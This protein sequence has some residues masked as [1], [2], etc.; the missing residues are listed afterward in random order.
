[1]SKNKEITLTLI[2]KN[3][4]KTL[5]N[6]LSSFAILYDLIQIIDT[7]SIDRTK[8]IALK[9]GAEIYDF[10]WI[11][12]FSAARNFGLKKVKTEWIMTVDAD[13]VIEEEDKNN[14]INHFLA[15]N[16]SDIFVLPYI[17][18]GTKT[19]PQT[20]NRQPRIWKSNLNLKYIRPIHER[21]SLPEN[22]KI[23]NLDIPIIHTKTNPIQASVQRN[24][25]ILN[26]HI[27]NNPEDHETAYYLG[28]EYSNLGDNIKSIEFY[29]KYLQL[30]PCN[31]TNTHHAHTKL[32]IIKMQQGKIIDAKKHFQTSIKLQPKVID[33][34]LFLAEI[35][36]HLFSPTNAIKLLSIAKELKSPPANINFCNPHLYSG[37]ADQLL[38]IA[39]SKL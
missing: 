6:C 20:I 10:E 30:E 8:E 17:Y 12:D 21:L 23:K 13:D 18:I 32:G 15:D 7:G 25:K 9:Y 26:E 37:K 14:L 33:S 1:M 35:E 29:E 28:M 19:N 27:K 36:M 11:H 4:E 38:Q 34:Y 22:A 2:V 3:E 31:T 16:S 5:A 39:L 24:L